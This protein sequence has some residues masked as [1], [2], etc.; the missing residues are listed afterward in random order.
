MLF[1]RIS[2]ALLVAMRVGSSVANPY[3]GASG[4]LV[5]VLV[6]GVAIRS[7]LLRVQVKES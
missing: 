7:I 3:L 4:I 5:F 2:R 6:L 1:A